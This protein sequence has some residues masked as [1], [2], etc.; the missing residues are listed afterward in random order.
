MQEA[1]YLDTQT[2][3]VDADLGQITSTGV[4]IAAQ[5]AP[6]YTKGSDLVLDDYYND[7]VASIV[8]EALLQEDLEVDEDGIYIVLAAEGVSLTDNTEEE[9]DGTADAPS[10]TF[11]SG[12]CGWH[13]HFYLDSGE[14]IKYAFVGN[15][16]GACMRTCAPL[17]NV[18]KSP[19]DNPA[20]DSIINTLAG[21]IVATQSNPESD[22]WRFYDSD[23]DEVSHSQGIL[24]RVVLTY[25]V[26]VDR[27]LSFLPPQLQHGGG[28]LRV[29]CGRARLGVAAQINST[30]LSSFC[31][32]R[33]ANSEHC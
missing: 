27:A 7:D 16:R 15:P 30:R 31:F 22:G 17:N 21:L 13:D 23:G 20:M 14:A 32:L 26:S 24:Q 28:L 12:T 3:Y 10:R 2:S 33:R 8:E 1:N 29:A 5:M 19:N 25:I 6:G 9:E 18:E 4:M 11:C